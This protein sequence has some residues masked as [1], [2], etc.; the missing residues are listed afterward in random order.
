MKKYLY[1]TVFS[2]TFL[3]GQMVQAQSDRSPSLAFG[4]QVTEPTGDFANQYK[5]LP[6]GFSTNFSVPVNNLPFEF[7][8][9]YAWNS[10]GSKNEDVSAYMYT[11]DSGAD[12][13]Q[14]GK[15]RIRNTINRYQIQTRFRPFN[16]KIQPYADAF[17]GVDA[18]KTKTDITIDNEGYS[19]ASNA[20]RKHLDMT[21]SFGWAAGLRIR[22]GQ[23]F[24]L[25][26]RFENITGGPASYVDKGTVVVT[27]DNDI[28]FE[29]KHSATNRFSYQLGIAIGF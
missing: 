17:A 21:Y 27:D 24:Y 23:N 13:Y 16:G 5:T 9:G 3:T 10:M 26:S 4:L 29:T 28:T 6:T 25:D 14:S 20:E 19:S 8:V 12:I 22:L 15:M 2:L 11:D 18:F 7:G 1:T